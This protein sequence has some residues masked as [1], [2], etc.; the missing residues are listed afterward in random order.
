MT[1]ISL[2]TR[3]LNVFA[4]VRKYMRLLNAEQIL[5]G[6]KASHLTKPLPF[7]KAIPEAKYRF[8]TGGHY[9]MSSILAD[10]LRPRI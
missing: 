1:N 5:L 3:G 10:Q 6:S 2:Q 7:R 4:C 8:D 9:E